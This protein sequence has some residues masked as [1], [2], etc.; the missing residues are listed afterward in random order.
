[1]THKIMS[2]WSDISQSTAESDTRYI[3][4]CVFSI[5]GGIVI[6]IPSIW[7]FIKYIKSRQSL[8]FALASTQQEGRSFS[9]L[10]D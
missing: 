5:L 1:M 4:I 10:L 7:Y 9:S 3:L 8:R 6:L 2:T